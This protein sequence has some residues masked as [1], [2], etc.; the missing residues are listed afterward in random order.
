M[1]WLW[2]GRCGVV[3]CDGFFIGVAWW[4]CVGVVWCDVMVVV[5]YSGCVLWLLF[6]VVVVWDG[7]FCGSCETLW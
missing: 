3:W 7:G 2:C 4:F 5:L 1:W 6:G